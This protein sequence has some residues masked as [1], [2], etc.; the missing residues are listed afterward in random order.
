ML[1]VPPN[2]QT[3]VSMPK[4]QIHSA[5]PPVSRAAGALLT[6]DAVLPLVALLWRADGVHCDGGDDAVQ[7]SRA[8]IER[9]SK[10]M[11]STPVTWC[12][13]AAHIR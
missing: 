3:A 8:G 6:N 4:H 10:A 1:N 11:M 2:N 12:C 7:N 13:C 5:G 9:R